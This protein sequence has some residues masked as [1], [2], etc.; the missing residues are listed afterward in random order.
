MESTTGTQK[1]ELRQ[2][3]IFDNLIEI[4]FFKGKLMKYLSFLTL[5]IVSN[6]AFATILGFNK[7]GGG[8]WD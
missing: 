4:K 8:T 7:T 2:L 5:L 1:N 6:V 3:S